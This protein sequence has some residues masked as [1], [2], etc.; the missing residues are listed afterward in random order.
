MT[1]KQKAHAAEFG[2]SLH[3]EED[4]VVL[5]WLLGHTQDRSLRGSWVECR[6]GSA[7]TYVLVHRMFRRCFLMRKASIASSDGSTIVSSSTWVVPHIDESLIQT[8]FRL[9][10]IIMKLGIA[11][12]LPRIPLDS[13]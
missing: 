2:R 11:D 8:S 7:Q 9:S 13:T 3:G 1:S 12:H 4:I 6:R 5:H 10:Q